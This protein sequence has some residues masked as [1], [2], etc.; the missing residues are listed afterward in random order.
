MTDV[1]TSQ[2]ANPANF[3]RNLSRQQTATDEKLDGKLLAGRYL[4]RSLLGRGGFGIT[5]LARN[6]YLPGQ[7]LCVI[8][9]LAPGFTDPELIAATHRQF[10]LEALSLSRLGSHAQIPALLDYFKIGTDS[11]LVEEYIPG[12]VLAQTI[13][14]QR[15][16]TEAE[17]A[18][19]LTR[20]LRLLE[21]IHGHHLIHRDIKPENIILCQIAALCW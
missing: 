2:S 14:K 21:Y 15:R 19:F 16:F 18:K 11:Y 1:V 9:K 3:E 8:K 20:M 5:F 13:E 12:I 4:V 17:V 7:P 6:I 10:D